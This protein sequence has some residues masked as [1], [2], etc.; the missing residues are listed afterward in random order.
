MEYRESVLKSEEKTVFLLR[1]LYQSFGYR[2]YKMSKFEEYDLYAG[3]KDF[4]IS[5]NIITFT[6]TN[7]RLMALKPDVTLSI[8]RNTKDMDGSVS[9]VF[10]DEN[11][12]RIPKG[13][14]AYKEIL[15]AGLECIGEIDNYC[16]GEVLYL[17]AASLGAISSG[18]LLN[19]SHLGIISGLLQ[20]MH[21]S[22]EQSQN[23]LRL[24]GEKNMHELK[25]LCEN[26]GCDAGDITRLIRVVSTNGAPEE[27]L[28]VLEECGCDKEA[29]TQLEGLC[30]ILRST[31]EADHI[32]ID[33]SVV[34]DMSYYNGIV[35]RG[36]IEGVPNGILSGGQYDKLLRK[37]GRK[38]RAVGFAVY[39]DFLERFYEQEP[40]LDT[41]VVLLY[42]PETDQEL[43][44][45]AVRQLTAEGLRVTAQKELPKK[46]RYGRVMRIDP[47]GVLETC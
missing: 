11:V 29:V 17:A 24:I 16:L 28:P 42:T 31:G 43:L 7:G 40:G 36:Y 34:N 15:Q 25:R 8:V 38:A 33:F 12:Y 45:R 30:R 23:V 47:E 21:L 26:A 13:S 19:I 10:Y 3:N 18:Y 32:V 2:Q 35:F 46:L 9:K 6:D 1:N 5:D 39:L 20:D 27:V 22:P 37:M 4:L 44:F 14:H 41:D